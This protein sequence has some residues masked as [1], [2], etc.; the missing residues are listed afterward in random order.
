MLGPGQHNYGDLD[1]GMLTTYR[2]GFT[3]PE[4][5]PPTPWGLYL[6]VAVAGW[7]LWSGGGKL[8]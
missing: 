8:S 4:P 2:Y 5:V 1:L 3:K 7:W 6:L